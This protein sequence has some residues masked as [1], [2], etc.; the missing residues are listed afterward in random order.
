MD[1]AIYDD[2]SLH[3]MPIFK[4]CFLVGRRLGIPS[5]M[6]TGVK[7]GEAAAGAEGLRLLE[8]DL[9]RN[10]NVKEMYLKV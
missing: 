7:T 3:K 10:V 5:G 6:L 4:L 9:A 1:L 2:K 8:A